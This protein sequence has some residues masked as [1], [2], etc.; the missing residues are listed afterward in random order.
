M[1]ITIKTPSDFNFRRTVLSHGWCALQPFEFDEQSWKLIRV[2]DLGQ[3]A[4]VTIEISSTNQQINIR[5][6]RRV[7]KKAASGIVRDVRHMFRLDDD[8]GEFYQSITGD[9]DFA[10]VAH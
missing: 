3:A 4:P 6:S 8:L 10:W 2:L 9:P 5:T 7:G 1:E